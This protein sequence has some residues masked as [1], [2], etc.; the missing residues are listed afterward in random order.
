MSL[1][2]LAA[3]HEPLEAGDPAIETVV[4]SDSQI[5]FLQQVSEGMS[6]GM[7]P[8]FGWPHAIRAILER[9]EES[10]IDLTAASSEEEIALLAAAKIQLRRN[11]EF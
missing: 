11:S 10:E 6:A 5:E 8:A 3:D 9:F 2:L 1:K 4:L 7:P